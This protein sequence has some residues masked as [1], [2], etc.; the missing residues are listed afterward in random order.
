MN[1]QRREFLKTGGLAGGALGLNLLGSLG[2][3]NNLFADGHSSNKKMLFIFQRGGNDGINAVIPRG[4]N[5]YNTTNRPTLFLRDNQAL[6]LGNGLGP[7]RETICDPD[8]L[9]ATKAFASSVRSSVSVI[10][11]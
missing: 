2:L 6:D 10:C 3:P 7:R 5:E 11:R 8:R 1:M 9:A 4:D